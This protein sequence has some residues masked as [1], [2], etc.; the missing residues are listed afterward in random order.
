[1]SRVHLLVYG[2]EAQ[3]LGQVK[4][5]GEVAN[6]RERLSQLGYRV[7]TSKNLKSINCTLKYFCAI[8]QWNKYKLFNS[9]VLNFHEFFILYSTNMLYFKY[10]YKSYFTIVVILPYIQSMKS[11]KFIKIL[12][13]PS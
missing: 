6:Y 1:M 4:T 12:G 2:L 5:G 7:Q 8:K 13:P 10:V 9:L 3:Q 11:M